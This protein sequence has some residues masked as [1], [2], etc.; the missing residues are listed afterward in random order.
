MGLGEGDV[1]DSNRYT[2]TVSGSPIWVTSAHGSAGGAIH[3]NTDDQTWV[4]TFT[5][6]PSTCPF[7]ATQCL[8]GFSFG[9][10]FKVDAISNS[11]SAKDFMRIG[12][13]S[14][15]RHHQGQNKFRV[16]VTTET[17]KWE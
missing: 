7:T 2:T 3:F 10:W 17:Q 11:N 15:I 1:R 16:Q 4:T 13:T 14:G 9:V 8:E 6:D 12:K 5:Q